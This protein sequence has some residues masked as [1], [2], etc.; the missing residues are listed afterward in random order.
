MLNPRP[1]SESAIEA[2]KNGAD[3]LIV[4]GAWT[5]RAPDLN[6]LMD[7][8]RDARAPIVIGSGLDEKNAVALM[9]YADAAIV[10]TSL[11]TGT[12][13]RTERNVKPY[14]MRISKEKVARLIEALSTFRK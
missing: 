10:S 4:T 9:H 13:K 2:E 14:S 12:R 8:K 11:K 1:I 6:K 7:V 3:A 5:G